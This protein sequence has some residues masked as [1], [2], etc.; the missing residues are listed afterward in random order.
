MK[1]GDLEVV[2]ASRE[3]LRSGVPVKLSSR[4]FDL[5]ELLIDANGALVSTETILKTVWPTTIVEEN[6][7]QVHIYALRRLLGQHR[8]LIQTSSGRGYRLVSRDPTDP[9]PHG[10]EHARQAP[11][12]SESREHS[13]PK[14]CEAMTLSG[15]PV[16]K[17]AF[18]GR[19]RYLEHIAS[20]I[21][22][23]QRRVITLVGVA[24]SG[25]SR[26]AVEAVKYLATAGVA[27]AWYVTLASVED[28]TH[29]WH[30]LN[31]MQ[32]RMRGEFDAR[33][34]RVPILVIDNCD[35]IAGA[36]VDFAQTAYASMRRLNIIVTSRAPLDMAIEK[37]IYVD[38]Q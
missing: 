19:T 31:E 15:F 38:A 36:V 29:A 6:N 37:V 20:A 7:I 27:R 26:L 21:G 23:A 3:V 17:S 28:P 4:A 25:K 8:H 16:F 32:H 33:S 34:F 30:I 9:E 18:F 10:D 2:R 12:L 22:E 1:I 11:W 14:S 35:L 13:R 24:G 5:L